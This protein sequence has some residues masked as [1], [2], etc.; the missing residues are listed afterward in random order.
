[1]TGDEVI[2]KKKIIFRPNFD[3][4]QLMKHS[5]KV[6]KSEKREEREELEKWK[7]GKIFDFLRRFAKEESAD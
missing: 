5:V 1:M 2:G 4:V 3:I 7:N 6:K